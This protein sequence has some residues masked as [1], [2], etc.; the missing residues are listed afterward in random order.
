MRIRRFQESVDDDRLLYYAFDWDDN[1]LFM[2][3]SIVVLDD[4]GDEINISTSE[5]SEYRELIGKENINHNGHT[6]VGYPTDNKGQVDFSQ[7]FRNFRDEYDND[8]FLKDTIESL[9]NKRFGPAWDDFI[10]CL[11][12]GSLFAIITARGHEEETIRKGV[13]YIINSYLSDDEKQKM[14]NYL[15]KY[16]YHAGEEIN[17]DRIVRGKFTEN[18]LVREYLDLCD[19]VGISAPSKEGYA[20]NPEEAKRKSLIEFK[21]KVDRLCGNLGKKCAIGFSDDDPGN[22]DNISELFDEINNEDFPNIDKLIIKDTHG[23]SVKKKEYIKK[24][25]SKINVGDK[26]LNIE[27]L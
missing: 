8:I 22:I 12:H 26:W 10:E 23:G 16:K 9:E 5:F 6:I 14:Y 21:K 7:A 13:E 19:F 15:L 25:E 1:L 24:F 11:T 17:F 20:D 4:K 27:D 2:T 3:T 18:P